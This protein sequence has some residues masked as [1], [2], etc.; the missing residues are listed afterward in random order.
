[1]WP[2]ISDGFSAAGNGQTRERGEEARWPGEPADLA[3]TARALIRFQR[4]PFLTMIRAR[5]LKI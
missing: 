3:L 2:R 4:K 1:M 5:A